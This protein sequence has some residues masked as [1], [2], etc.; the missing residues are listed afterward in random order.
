[1]IVEENLLKQIKPHTEGTQE[2]TDKVE[3]MSV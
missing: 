3:S 2:L 1:M